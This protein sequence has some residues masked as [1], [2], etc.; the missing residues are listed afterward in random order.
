MPQPLQV[1]FHGIS[2]HRLS[3]PRCQAASYSSH[4]NRQPTA[5]EHHHSVCLQRR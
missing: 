4:F 3:S 1:T 2:R 5:P